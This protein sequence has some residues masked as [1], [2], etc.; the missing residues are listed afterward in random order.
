M[1]H[2]VKSLPA[3]EGNGN[4]LRYSCLKRLLDR[5][6]WRATVHGVA[7]LGRT[8]QLTHKM[9]ETLAGVRVHLSVL[10]SPAGSRMGQAGWVPTPTPFWKS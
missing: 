4:P 10:A 3:G 6:A 5:G 9:E 8:E 1:T 2:V 7:E